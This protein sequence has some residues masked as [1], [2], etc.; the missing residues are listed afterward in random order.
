MVDSPQG[1]PSRAI[2]A[3]RPIFCARYDVA[4]DIAY[5]CFGGRVGRGTMTVPVVNP[6]P[7]VAS[8]SDGPP[9]CAIACPTLHGARIK[10]MP[11]CQHDRRRS[12]SAR[13]NNC[14]STRWTPLARPHALHFAGRG[15]VGGRGRKTIPAATVYCH[16]LDLYHAEKA[17]RHAGNDLAES[18]AGLLVR[19]SPS[20]GRPGRAAVECPRRG[21]TDAG[22]VARGAPATG[23]RRGP[24]RKH[25]QPARPL[26]ARGDADAVCHGDPPRVVEGHGLSWPRETGR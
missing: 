1:R 25:R 4:W 16:Y 15:P 23:S 10:C 9:C 26:V 22:I 17:R 18:H 11:E 6:R 12:K 5:R 21:G 14:S 13:R 8:V 7:I 24:H 19:F 3:G 2:S 20:G